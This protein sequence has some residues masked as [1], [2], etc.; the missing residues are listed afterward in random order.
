MIGFGSAPITIKNEK[1]KNHFREIL[2][3]K[4]LVY[5]INKLTTEKSTNLRAMYC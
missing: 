2:E 5:T 3:E 1:C 4:F